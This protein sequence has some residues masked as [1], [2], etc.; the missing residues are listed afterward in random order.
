MKADAVKNF[1]NE[2]AAVWDEICSHDPAI[3]EKLLDFCKIKQGDRVLDVACGT[4]IL[5]GFLLA[6]GAEILGVDFAEEMILRAKEKYTDPRVRFEARDIFSVTEDAFDLVIVYSAFP[7][8][9]DRAALFSHLKDRL[10]SGG[11]IVI[12]HSE[13][14][15]AIDRRHHGAASEISLSLPPAEELKQTLSVWLTPEIAVEN[16]EYYVV[17]ALKE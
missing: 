6:R 16:E 8:F 10:K 1:F 4:G 9:P 14:R 5:T 13:S 12:C 11:R 15:A 17:S 7:H 2:R 3:I